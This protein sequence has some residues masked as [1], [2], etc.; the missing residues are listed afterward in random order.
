MGRGVGRVGRESEF[1]HRRK[2][3][4]EEGRMVKCSGG[5]IARVV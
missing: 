3:W 4:V 5:K 1:G 2:G